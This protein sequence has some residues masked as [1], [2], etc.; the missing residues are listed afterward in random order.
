MSRNAILIVVTVLIVLV[1]GWWLLQAQKG[2]STLPPLPVTESITE[3]PTSAPAESTEAGMKQAEKNSVTISSDGFNPK[4]VTIKAGE[5]V[6]WMNDDTKAHTVNSEPHPTHTI[7][8]PFNTVGR[9]SP[10]EQKS[11]AFP[12]A[13]TYGY[14]DHLNPSLTGTV[15]VQ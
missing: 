12:D 15:I 8:A 7:Y 6:T 1:A 13:G 14:H 2:T 10:G 9:L 3:T 11:L 4:S 5:E